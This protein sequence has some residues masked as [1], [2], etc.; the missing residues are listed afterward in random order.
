[1]SIAYILWTESV[2]TRVGRCTPIEQ[3]TEHTEQLYLYEL[4]LST[5]Y[6]E[7]KA[8]IAN[9]IRQMFLQPS[10][11][12][13]AAD[14]RST[15]SASGKLPKP[16]DMGTSEVMTPSS[17]KQ[18]LATSCGKGNSPTFKVPIC[19]ISKFEAASKCHLK[20]HVMKQA[21]KWDDYAIKHCR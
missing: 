12:T 19:G 15:T 14:Q 7:A 2:L 11:T 1:M 4:T 17:S 3:F 5:D 8:A 10:A 9:A 16:N 6:K 21:G 13:A 18:T 20:E